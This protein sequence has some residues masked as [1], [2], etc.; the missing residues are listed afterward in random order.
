MLTL[1]PHNLA[2][3]LS[4]WANSL[5]VSRVAMK[6]PLPHLTSRTTVSAP[7]ANFLL[8]MLETISGIELTVSVTSRRAY[9]HF[10]GGSQIWRLTR[11]VPDRVSTLRS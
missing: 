10:V 5:A 2:V 8:R 4:D 1:S 6:E 11:A 9:E 7:A 3:W